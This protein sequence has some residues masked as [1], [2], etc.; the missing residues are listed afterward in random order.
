MTM[1]HE[2]HHEPNAE[3]P[4]VHGMLIVGDV[5]VL[6]SHLPMFHA[7]HDYQIIIETSLSAPGF[8]PRQKYVDDRHATLAPIY[9]WVPKPFVLSDLLKPNPAPPTMV[10]A[11]F[12]GHFERGGIAITGDDVEARVERILYSRRLIA[13]DP[14]LTERRYF[15]FGSPSE[16]F[17]AHVITRPPDFDQITA[18]EIAAPRAD[19]LT[20]WRGVGIALKIDGI[21]R[22]INAPLREGDQVNATKLDAPS[23]G[24]AVL[25]VRREFYL[26]T[27]DLA[28]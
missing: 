17:L 18:V 7:P 10:G 12:R 2:H 21:D 9:T 11:I 28:P 1:P 13:S 25:T 24:S 5:R 14:P 4:A 27:G 3:Q 6:M 22:A 16:P 15:I 20:D 26:E 23:A 8:D 19:W